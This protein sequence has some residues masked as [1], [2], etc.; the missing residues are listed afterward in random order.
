M[1]TE[2]VYSERG[3]GGR[4]GAGERPCLVVIDMNYG[5]TDPESPLHCDT[6]DA[7]ASI[8]RLLDAAREAGAPV[9]FTTLEYDEGAKQVA[10]AF[11]AKSPGLLVLAPGTRWPQID[12]RI[13]P[14]EGEPL[15]YKLFASAFHGTPLAAMLT[16]HGCDTVIVTGASTSGCVRATAVDAL[17]HGYRVIVPREAVADR[18]PGAH[19]ASLTDI[20]AKYGDVVG[21]DEAVAI[22][23]G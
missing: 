18:A 6:D 7:V 23:R 19:D 2:D 16:S 10:K 20:D 17:Q 22:L 4:Q 9:A 5:F 1:S 11:I 8:A 21:T 14:R 3:F 13:A 15:L 12:E